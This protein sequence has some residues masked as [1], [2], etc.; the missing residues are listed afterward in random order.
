MSNPKL[1]RSQFHEK[2]ALILGVARSGLAAA[3]LIL[4]LG[5]TVVLYDRK[6]LEE[7]Q[8]DQ[9]LLTHPKVKALWQGRTA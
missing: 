1:I 7:L 9:E 3:K 2:Q 8:I 5:G 6:S 4:Y